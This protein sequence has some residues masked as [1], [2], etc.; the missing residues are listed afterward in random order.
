MK[1]TDE[2][3]GREGSKVGGGGSEKRRSVNADLRG[4]PAMG[5]G[6][7][8]SFLLLVKLSHDHRRG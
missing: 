3:L 1:V 5:A 6:K 2:R 4:T 7:T 8:S